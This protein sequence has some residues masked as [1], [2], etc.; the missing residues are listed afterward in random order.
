M[1]EELRSM[2]IR[3]FHA[4]E[5][6]NSMVKTYD[7][8]AEKTRFPKLLPVPEDLLRKISN[9]LPD[10]KDVEHLCQVVLGGWDYFITTDF[11]T[12]L[13]RAEY[14]KFIGIIAIKD[15]YGDVLKLFK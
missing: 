8:L 12:I 3:S 14:L 15:G 10:R 13:C 1:Q 6:K 2:P 5:K 4:K 9:A 11:K 7:L